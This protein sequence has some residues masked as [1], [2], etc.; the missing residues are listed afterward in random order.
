MQG[1]GPELNIVLARGFQ[2]LSWLG[3]LLVLQPEHM[4]NPRGWEEMVAMCGLLQKPGKLVRPVCAPSCAPKLHETIKVNKVSSSSLKFLC[5]EK[6][7]RPWSNSMCP[8][9]WCLSTDIMPFPKK[10]TGCCQMYLLLQIPS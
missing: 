3:T 1:G 2:Q 4:W 8:I 10:K 5:L 9:L 7:K 6:G